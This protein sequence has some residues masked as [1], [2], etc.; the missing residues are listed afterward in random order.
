MFSRTT[1]PRRRKLS[2]AVAAA[3][4]LTLSLAACGGGSDDGAGSGSASGTG[5]GTA[6]QG[7]AVTIPLATESRGLDPFTASYT[8]SADSSRMAALYD[9]LVYLD[10]ADGKVKPRIAESLTPDATGA[11]WTLK[12]KPNVKFSD[13]TPYDAAAVKANWDANN[14]PAMNSI[15]RVN[16]AGVTSEVTGPLELKVTLAKPSLNFDRNVVNGLTYI[17][18]PTAFKADPKGFAGKPVGAGPFVLKEWVRGNRQTLVRNPT[19][20]QAGLPKLDQVTFTVISDATQLLNTLGNGQADITVTS[21]AEADDIA[22]TKHL[23]ALTTPVY[24]GQYFLMNTRRAPFDDPRARRALAMALDSPAMMKTLY[25]DNI[26]AADSVF[27]ENSPLVDPAVPAQPAYNQAEAQKLFD[28]LAAE[29][30]PVRFTYLTQ[31]N[32]NARKTAEYMQSRLNQYKNVSMEIEAVEVGAYIT[33]GLVNRDFQA[34]NFGMWLVDPDPGIDSLYRSTSPTNYSGYNNPAADAA[35][36]KAR[37]ASTE[38]ARRAAY[39]ELVKITAQDVPLFVWQE[40][41]T[42][43]VYRSTVTGVTMVNDGAMLMDQVGLKK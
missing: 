43:I 4:A 23:E 19:Y 26:K 24:G 34:Q 5:G 20:W 28:E 18:S 7:G 13:G 37:A 21:N 30:K 14:D 36:D 39:T 1:P 2:A 3:V 16:M 9:F 40:A 15:H 27:K 41:V 8:G 33:K 32:T 31:Q 25:G 35:L 29:G 42:V 38:E 6:K 11:V 17:A 12:I 10:P 22:K